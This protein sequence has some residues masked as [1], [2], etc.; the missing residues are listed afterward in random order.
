[1][2]CPVGMNALANQCALASVYVPCV[3]MIRALVFTVPKEILSCSVLI[4]TV[5]LFASAVFSSRLIVRG[6]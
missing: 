6:K 1:M 2:P 4:A 5:V 3:T